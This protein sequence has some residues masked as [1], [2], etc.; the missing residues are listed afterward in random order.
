MLSLSDV[1]DAAERLRGVAVRTP[2]LRSRTLDARV[3][4]RVFVKAENH[5]RTGSFKFRGAYNR[6]FRL[7]PADLERGVVAVSSGN[8]AQAVALAARLV[9][10]RAVILMPSDAPASKRMATEA[11]GAEVVAFDRYTQS[12]D[13]LVTELVAARGGTFIP[14]YDDLH[15]MA[16]QGTAALELFDEVE[17]LDALIVPV[18]GGGLIAGCGVAARSL[19]FRLRLIGVEPE[20]GDDTRRSLAAGRRIR[21][22]VPRTIADAL[23]VDVP[24]ELTFE[25]NRRQVDEVVTVTD[26]E[27][28]EAMRFCFE[29]MKTV[30][31]PSGAAGVA[32][33]LAGRI[34]PQG[35]VGVILS[36]GNVD[37]RRFADLVASA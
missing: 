23:T 10:T 35:N 7:A 11:Y 29:T 17:E 25:I 4:A 28:V 16:G 24:G 31:E 13:E 37:A 33:L 6:I 32:A 18:S 30:A 34:R 26:T 21:L 12:R 5:Q 9:G 27:L 1:R 36:G 19:N 3:G 8:H 22:P 20:D 15:V 14:P 2:V